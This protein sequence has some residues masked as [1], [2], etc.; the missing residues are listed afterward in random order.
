MVASKR[1]IIGMILGLFGVFLLS[2]G[3]KSTFSDEETL[4]RQFTKQEMISSLTKTFVHMEA[5]TLGQKTMIYFDERTRAELDDFAQSILKTI[6]GQEGK[7]LLHIADPDL[8]RTLCFFV[9]RY[10]Y[11]IEARQLPEE[12]QVYLVS[13]QVKDVHRDAV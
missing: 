10:V 8:H 7:K 6:V 5:E 4:T 3:L 9:T 12:L 11:A 1:S 13:E 2:G